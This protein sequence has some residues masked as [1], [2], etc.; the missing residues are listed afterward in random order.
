MANSKLLTK[1]RVFGISI[2]L[3]ELLELYSQ[4]LGISLSKFVRDSLEEKIEKLK[5][6]EQ[7]FWREMSTDKIDEIIL[8]L[9]KYLDSK[10]SSGDSQTCE[11]SSIWENNYDEYFTHTKEFCKDLQIEL[12]AF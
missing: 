6:E 1:N 12:N 7:K 11:H 9:M 10:F 8:S 2:E 4:R 5:R 3:D